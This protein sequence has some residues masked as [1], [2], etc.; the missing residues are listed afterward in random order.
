[1][2]EFETYRVPSWEEFCLKHEPTN[3]LAW[4]EVLREMEKYRVYTS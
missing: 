3:S 4:R 1:M 2:K